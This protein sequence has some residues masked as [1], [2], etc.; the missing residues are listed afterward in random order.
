MS[1]I[2]LLLHYLSVFWLWIGS[3]SFKGYEKDIEPWQF[4]NEDFEGYSRYQ[5]YVLSVYWV[6]TVITTVGYGDY[7][8]KTNIE[9][10]AMIG[11]EFFGLVVFAVLQVAVTQMVG[12]DMTYG[13]FIGEK[14]I[15]ILFWM[16]DLENSKLGEPLP[17][18]LFR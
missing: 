3:E 4:F 12:Y 17:P 1:Y 11:L 5:L 15:S 9:Y 7:S 2:A 18:D 8:G 13:K 14:D 10:L 16:W 6:C